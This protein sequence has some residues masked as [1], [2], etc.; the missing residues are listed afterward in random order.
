MRRKVRELQDLVIDEISLVD[1]GANQHATVTIAKRHGEEEEMDQYYDENGNLVDIDSLSHGDVVYDADQ[2]AYQFEA[3]EVEEDIYEPELAG[4]SKVFERPTAHDSTFAEDLRVELSKALTDEDRDAV[5]AKAFSQIDTI[6]KAAEEA[7]AAA[8][9]ERQLRLEREYT[10]VAK[11]YSVGVDPEELGPVL[12]RMAETMDEED[13]AV[14]AKALDS[15]SGIAEQ[16]FEE[17]GKR[18]GGANSDV[19]MQV[20]EII[21]G[22]VAK[23]DLPREEAVASYFE[24]NPEAYDSYLAERRGY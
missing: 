8:E 23:G 18:G 21:D 12:M 6:S 19:F 22:Q 13:C 14:I 1:R 24:T 2:N 7:R 16:Y 9:A 4:V 17:V 20:E 5:I 11:S 15:A 10:E 3:D